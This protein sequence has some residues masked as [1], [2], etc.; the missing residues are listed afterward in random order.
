MI[1]QVSMRICLSTERGRVMM[2]QNPSIF[3]SMR[4]CQY[5]HRRPPNVGLR[6]GETV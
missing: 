5:D 2:F 4:R 1:A 6:L 3:H